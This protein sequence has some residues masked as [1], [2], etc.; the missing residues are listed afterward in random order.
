[1]C[2]TKPPTTVKLGNTTYIGSQNARNDRQIGPGGQ[3]PCAYHFNKLADGQPAEYPNKPGNGRSARPLRWCSIIGIR[4]SLLW[5][6]LVW[7]VA[8][9]RLRERILLLVW[10]GLLLRVGLLLL[11]HIVHGLFFDR[12][13][14][15]VLLGQGK[16]KRSLSNLFQLAHSGRHTK[17]SRHSRVLRFLGVFFLPT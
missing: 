10:V 14:L 6:A 4:H 2:G 7:R 1:M 15:C 12:L 16:T 11:G 8:R 9:L 5:L 3:R 17:W 13:R